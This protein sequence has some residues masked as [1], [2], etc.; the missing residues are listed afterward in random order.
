MNIKRSLS[1]IGGLILVLLILVSISIA[2]LPVAIKWQVNGWFEDQGLVSHIDELDVSLTD[3]QISVQGFTVNDTGG[4]KYLDIGKLFLQLGIR[5][6]VDKLISIEKVEIDDV[7][8][9]AE[10][11][12]QGL[13]KVAGI[14]AGPRVAIEEN[15]DEKTEKEVKVAVQD[16]WHFALK[17]IMLSNIEFCY[18]APKTVSSRAFHDCASL[19][20]F[21]WNGDAR[22]TL[23]SDAN[24]ALSE[25]TATFNSNLSGF[26]VKD[27]LLKRTVMRFDELQ[28][29]N[30]SVN[31]INNAEIGKI[32]LKNYQSLQASADNLSEKAN[33]LFSSGNMVLD[34]I[35]VKDLSLVDVKTVKVS[36]LN[37]AILLKSD[38]SLQAQDA[39]KD[40]FPDESRDAGKHESIDTRTTK[41]SKPVILRLGELAISGQSSISIRDESVKPVF[42]NRLSNIQL[43]VKD[44]DMSDREKETQINLSLVVGEYGEVKTK[45]KIQL[46]SAKPTLSMKVKVVGINIG[47]F[48]AY[49]N[50]LV[51]H[52][53]KSG[54]LDGDFDIKIDEGNLDTKAKVK[55]HKFYV[56]TLGEKEANQYNEKLGVPLGTALSL[57]REKDDSISISMPITG[58]VENPDFSLADII[59][60]V[61]ALAIKEAVINYYTPFGLVKLLKKGFSL[62]TALRFEPVLFEPGN[63]NL[64]QKDKEQL[65]KLATLL[66]ERPKLH[67]VVCGYTTQRDFKYFYP[68]ETAKIKRMLEKNERD[69]EPSDE[70]ADGL[71]EKVEIPVLDKQQEKLDDLAGSRG[72]V[73]KQ[74]LVDQHKIEKDRLILCNPK[75][76]FTETGE[77]RTEITI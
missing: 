66:N 5:D 20:S 3:G 72:K 55:L 9:G 60:K 39:I 51:Q 64:D 8:V 57:L 77:M 14:G 1:Y 43:D 4:E 75:F 76:D 26:S 7:Y 56:E 2:M 73:V 33:Y 23:Y 12:A 67:L 68:K 44:I 22:Y 49:A 34:H 37:A 70:A 50:Q 21:I 53:V 61:S 52:K 30:V 13:F 24:K 63:A 6:L 25:I 10:Q 15:V 17:E 47:E 27:I 58:D 45:G 11:D 18:R 32:S 19:E 29:E 69:S 65:D 54:H 36:G 74:Y 40:F 35:L 42:N 71:G 16:P 48:D 38:G 31:S 28:F 46:L 41:T 59:R 62:A